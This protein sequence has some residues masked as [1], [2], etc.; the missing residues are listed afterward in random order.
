MPEKSVGSMIWLLLPGSDWVFIMIG[1]SGLL[2][3]SS[4]LFA[5]SIFMGRVQ[6]KE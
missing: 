3:V 5:V 1:P 4:H 2:L 6:K